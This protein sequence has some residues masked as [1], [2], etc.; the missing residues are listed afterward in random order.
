MKILKIGDKVKV[1]GVPEKQK[2][3][4]NMKGTVIPIEKDKYSDNDVMVELENK[5][6]ICVKEYQLV[7]TEK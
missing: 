5:K 7:K 4:L 1:V 3:A 2:Y 6:L